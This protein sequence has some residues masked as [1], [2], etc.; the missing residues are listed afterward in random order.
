MSEEQR[1]EEPETPRPESPPDRDT[2]FD[3][4]RDMGEESEHLDEVMQD[5][6]DAVSAAHRADSMRAAGAQGGDA[7]E[8]GPQ[9]SG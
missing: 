7:E 5:A 1:V 3:D 4:L 2:R 9:A 6:R 8:D